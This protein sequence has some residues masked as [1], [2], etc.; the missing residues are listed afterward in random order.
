MRDLLVLSIVIYFLPQVF[1]K[2]YIGVLLMCWFGYMN[3]H[4]MGWGFAYNLPFFYAITLTTLICTLIA[5]SKKDAAP[6]PAHAITFTL[7]TFII[8]L[9]VTSLNAVYTDNAWV[10]YIK[11][12]KIQVGILLTLLLINSE[13]KLIYLIITIAL[14]IGFFGIKGGVFSLMTGGGF[15][16]WGPPDSFIEGNNELALA[17]L[18]ILP[19]FYFLYF[20]V[21]RPLVKKLI[22]ASGLLILISVVFSYSRGAFLALAASLFFLW[23]R[24]QKKMVLAVSFIAILIVAIPFVPSTWFDRMNTIET[25]E[26]DESAQ[27]RFNSWGFAYNVAKDKITGGGFNVWEREM[28]SIYAPNPAVV[29]DA[30]SIYFEVLGE[31]GFIGL[32]LFIGFF[33]LVWREAGKIRKKY[34]HS[35][36]FGWASNLMA[37]CQVSLV[38]YASG[39][40]FLG[41]AFFD[42]P[43]HIATFVLIT[44]RIVANKSSSGGTIDNKSRPSMGPV[45]AVIKSS[46]GNTEERIE[47][48]R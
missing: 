7:A 46:P 41:L 19:Y 37:M 16:V 10:A 20:Y 8:W 36:D 3:P 1:K 35:P 30:H 21:N 11:F 45:T 12:L 43:Y 44:H 25:Y 24:S 18:V 22:L 28:F 38:A 48:S 13:K 23:F 31:H 14:S 26:E 34:L 9:L 2:P 17:L 40:A 39:G 32:F 33:Y 15:R 6:P 47:H 4:R 27:G 42:L 29:F 5:F